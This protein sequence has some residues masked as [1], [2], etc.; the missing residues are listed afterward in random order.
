MARSGGPGFGG[1]HLAL[2]GFNPLRST[3]QDGVEPGQSVV[4][5][6][7]NVGIEVHG[8]NDRYVA[9][10]GETADGAGNRLHAESQGSFDLTLEP[11]LDLW[12]FGPKGQGEAVPSAAQLAAVQPGRD[13]DLADAPNFCG[14]LPQL[15]R[16]FSEAAVIVAHQLQAPQATVD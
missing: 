12:G 2:R 9:P 5:Y 15:R 10:S 16:V 13:A 1:R 8:E 4:H 6:G 3:C 11:L 7:P 14:V